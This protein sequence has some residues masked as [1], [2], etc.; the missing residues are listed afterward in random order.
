MTGLV[1]LKDAPKLK[2]IIKKTLFVARYHFILLG[3]GRMINL[4]G[5]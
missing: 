2:I 3:I 4:W 5:G 1:F